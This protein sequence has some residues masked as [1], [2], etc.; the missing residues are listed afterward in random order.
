[1]CKRSRDLLEISRAAIERS[2]ERLR[3]HVLIKPP[4][5]GGRWVVARLSMPSARCPRY[6]MSISA[7]ADHYQVFD[8]SSRI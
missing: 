8:Q 7:L 5:G 6:R 3:L 1:M 4:P 2:R